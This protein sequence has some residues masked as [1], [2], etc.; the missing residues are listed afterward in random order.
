VVIAA[1]IMLGIMGY[2]SDRIIVG[3]QR[4]VLRWHWELSIHAE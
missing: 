4:V 1:M 2:L 3:I